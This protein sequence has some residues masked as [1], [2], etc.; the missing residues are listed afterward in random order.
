MVIVKDTIPPVS[1]IATL[2]TVAGECSATI[3][4][5]P[6]AT[7]NCAGSITGTTSDPL[8]YSS[9][10]TYT[11]HWTYNDG[12]GNTSNQT[13]TV[14]IKDVTPPVISGCP[15]NKTVY[16]GS[17][18][19][20]CDQT[21]SWTPPTASDNCAVVSFTSNYPS[22]ATFPVG[23]TTVKYLAVDVGGNKDSCSFTVTVIDNTPPV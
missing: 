15:S 8:T 7:D 18:R 3:I 9:Q 11:V 14:A 6:K 19:T 5:P 4:T 2:S 13:Q 10:G 12:N 20:T 1:N 17:G 23:T 16:T 21:A 22:G